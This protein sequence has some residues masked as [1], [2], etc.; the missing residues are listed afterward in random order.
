MTLVAI[1]V[2]FDLATT[3]DA[4]LASTDESDPD[5][6]A[7][8]L[9]EDVS[10]EQLREAFLSALPSYVRQR[11]ATRNAVLTRTARYSSKWKTAR[12]EYDQTILDYRVAMLD[13]KRLSELTRTEV[14][15]AAKAHR[16]LAAK[17]RE[18]AKCYDRLAAEMKERGVRTVA[19]LGADKVEAIWRG[20]F[21]A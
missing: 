9:A 21:N 10:D 16:H 12:Q 14:L 2:G 19:D 17:E 6:I 13:H 1:E 8:A 11:M 15:A 5:T 18:H 20:D 3:V 7:A 4:C